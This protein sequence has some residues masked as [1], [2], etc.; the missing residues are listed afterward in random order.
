MRP[1][2]QK[3]KITL[4]YPT[5]GLLFRSRVPC[6]AV[7]IYDERDVPSFE[8]QHWDPMCTSGIAREDVVLVQACREYQT[9]MMQTRIPARALF[10]VVLARYFTTCERFSMLTYADAYVS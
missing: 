9:R 4:S 2:T 10:A 5:L 1:S 3:K 6:P 7:D 8:V